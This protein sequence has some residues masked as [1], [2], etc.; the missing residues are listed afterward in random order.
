LFSFPEIDITNFQGNHS[1]L[2]DEIID[3]WLLRI[4]GSYEQ[5]SSVVNAAFFE[6]LYQWLSAPSLAI[7]LKNKQ[8]SI[9]ADKAFEEE[10]ERASHRQYELDA[11]EAAKWQKKLQPQPTPPPIIEFI[12]PEIP[13][14]D[15]ETVEP[16]ASDTSAG[17]TE[18][19]SPSDG[20]TVKPEKIPQYVTTENIELYKQRYDLQSLYSLIL[21]ELP[22]QEE[23]ENIPYGSLFHTYQQ[24]HQWF[25]L[26]RNIISTIKDADKD[27]PIT[28]LFQLIRINVVEYIVDGNSPLLNYSTEIIATLVNY[29]HHFC[30]FEID[31]VVHEL[32][33]LLKHE[34]APVYEDFTRDKLH[35]IIKRLRSESTIISDYQLDVSSPYLL[36]LSRIQRSLSVYS[37]SL[38]NK[39]HTIDLYIAL[40]KH[41]GFKLR[42]RKPTKPEDLLQAYIQ[43]AVTIPLASFKRLSTLRIEG[44]TETYLYNRIIL[45]VI[46]LEPPQ[47]IRTVSHTDLTEHIQ[48]LQEDPISEVL[49]FQ[50]ASQLLMA[51]IQDGVF[52]PTGE[53][54]IAEFDHKDRL[55]SEAES[56]IES[57][58]DEESIAPLIT[59]LEQLDVYITEK[60]TL[61]RSS[62]HGW[63]NYSD[64]VPIAPSVLELLKLT[65]I[66]DLIEKEQQWFDSVCLKQYGMNPVQTEEMVQELLEYSWLSELTCS[67]ESIR[68]IASKDIPQNHKRIL[69]NVIV[70]SYISTVFQEHL[71]FIGSGTSQEVQSKFIY[72]LNTYS[73]S[74][75]LSQFQKG[76]KKDQIHDARLIHSCIQLAG[77]HVSQHSQQWSLISTM[78]Q[79][80][81]P[82]LVKNITHL[83]TGDSDALVQAGLNLW[84][85]V[86]GENPNFATSE[87]GVFQATEQ[88]LFPEM[89]RYHV[90][91]FLNE[92]GVQ[93]RLQW[94]EIN[95]IL[96][97]Y[98]LAKRVPDQFDS[99]S[100]YTETNKDQAYY[101]FNTALQAEIENL[102]LDTLT[103][104][105][106]LDFKRTIVSILAGETIS[107]LNPYHNELLLEF[108]DISLTYLPKSSSHRIL[109]LIKCMG[110]DTLS[111]LAQDDSIIHE[112]TVLYNFSGIVS[113]LLR[114]GFSLIDISQ[115]SSYLLNHFQ[116]ER[117]L[118]SMKS[119]NIADTTDLENRLLLILEE[120]GY[121]T[122]QSEQQTMT[123]REELL[124]LT[125]NS[126]SL[127][128]S[129]LL[130]TPLVEL[131]F[132][133][134][135]GDLSTPT[136][137]AI[138]LTAIT[139]STPTSLRQYTNYPEFAEHVFSVKQSS[140]FSSLHIK[141]SIVVIDIFLKQELYRSIAVNQATEL[142]LEVE[143][144]HTIE[145][146]LRDY[147]LS[148][149]QTL[150]TMLQEVAVLTDQSVA[151]RWN[152]DEQIFNTDT[153]PPYREIFFEG[154]YETPL[155]TIFS[156]QDNSIVRQFCSYSGITDSHY[157]SG[158]IQELSKQSWISSKSEE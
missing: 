137:N 96:F 57:A 11:A 151:M 131:S 19:D 78:N 106:Y 30:P 27:I 156:D 28:E 33:V 81:Q 109:D 2:E 94:E 53:A 70:A 42:G 6:L 17:T 41:L 77:S 98:D 144:L 56:I 62:E 146:C 84:S 114:D 115:S 150:Q 63:Y 129:I 92:T 50:I 105:D 43:E 143:Y 37:Y 134:Y 21:P 155:T 71:F 100:I 49:P 34:N 141:T 73:G 117:A 132:D 89:M 102:H 99:L 15:T 45:E 36:T 120:L 123:L 121:K 51:Q 87:Y 22:T 111:T 130:Q 126:S 107:T 59:L 88:N 128:Q 29:S 135:E 124:H 91:D 104:E 154:L 90:L 3:Q 74:I 9:E 32:L 110:Q 86:I 72:T 108:Y 82:Y 58:N 152:K 66:K 7:A 101:L 79:A 103:F 148:S 75:V 85:L 138:I 97:P 10:A 25:L 48:S 8:R 116:I 133:D 64:I 158:I 145:D 93:R 153:T 38:D 125:C 1:F 140:E 68:T 4:Y 39:E 118:L 80:I 69:L 13:D 54:Y 149:I 127:S 14:V 35:L 12:E 44:I 95:E 46:G 16:P 76:S 40:F 18:S 147:S 157:I 60:V 65:T 67:R 31:P 136:Q 26:A 142:Q 23:L 139:D 83:P 119:E 20:E 55:L 112:T 5:P 47:P 113:A 24:P 61:Q 52:R 122:S